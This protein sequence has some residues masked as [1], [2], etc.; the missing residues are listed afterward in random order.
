MCRLKFFYQP[1]DNALVPVVATK[2]GVTVG[3]LYFEYAIANFKHADVECATA[4]VEHENCLV[5]TAFVEPVSECCCS[6][7]VDDPQNFEASDLPCF[8][9]RSALRVVEICR[10]GDNC[11]RH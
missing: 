2:V 3:A 4:K 10:H 6:R 9:C 5:F 7:L 1:I 11:L 8:F